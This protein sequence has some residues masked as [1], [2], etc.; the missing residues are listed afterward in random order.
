MYYI[1]FYCNFKACNSKLLLNNCI[2]ISLQILLIT[3]VALSYY[4]DYIAISLEI[5][6]ITKVPCVEYV[7]HLFDR[8]EVVGEVPHVLGED[9]RN[10]VVFWDKGHEPLPP[11]LIQ[12]VPWN[13]ENTEG[14]LGYIYKY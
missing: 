4:N 7:A 6:L 9:P 11:K 3:R 12:A 5:L 1:T 14:V 13:E 8:V 2:A 10:Q